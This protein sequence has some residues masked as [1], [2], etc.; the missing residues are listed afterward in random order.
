M[1]VGLKKAALAVAVLTA[2]TF[3]PV[4]QSEAGRSN[5]LKLMARVLPHA[6]LWF[7][8]WTF[9]LPAKWDLT[10][11]GL[12]MIQLA[13]GGN[14]GKFTVSLVSRNAEETG[15]TTLVDP[16][17]GASIGYRLRYA[18]TKV[19]FENGA[20]QLAAVNAKTSDDPAEA[21]PLELDVPPGVDLKG[22]N[23]QDQLVVVVT[24]R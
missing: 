16:T 11:S 23:F 4:H 9:G 1:A 7:S 3:G 21:R 14:G 5:T 13:A 17:T 6:R 10:A 24:A 2:E 22:G 20:A 18:G 19:N 8:N 12:W 15:Q